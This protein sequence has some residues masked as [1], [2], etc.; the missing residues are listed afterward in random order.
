MPPHPLGPGDLVLCAGTLLATPFVERL[1]PARAAGFAGVSIWPHD[2]ER[3]GVGVAELRARVADHGLA[4]AEMD[5]ITTWLPGHRPPAGLD[6]SVARN[7]LSNT[8]ERLCPLA[9][10]LGARSCT[11]V[12]YY[13]AHV[14]LDAAAEA[15]A[16][17]CDRAAQHGLLVHLE[18]LP[19]TQIPD[20]ATAW[21]IVR[22]AG[23]ANGGLLVDSWHL[24]RGGNTPDALRGIPGERILGVQLDDA[25]A[26]AEA[27]LA[28]ETQHRRLLP[29][30]GSFDLVAL[31]RMLDALGCRAPVGVEVFSDAL[32]ER[33]VG[34]VAVRS[35]EATRRVLAAARNPR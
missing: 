8:A 23:R 17:V 34:E 5:A 25:P 30:E 14:A 19:W 9:E 3:S 29:G 18:F 7:L 32:A 33:P 21:E 31:L 22:R 10:A 15:F 6:A 13:G 24:F 26:K 16:L 28:E 27:D 4:I 20:P 1:A 11:L 2:V 35:A 12:E